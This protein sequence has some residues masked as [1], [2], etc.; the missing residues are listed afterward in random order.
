MNTAPV[1]RLVRRLP[2]TPWFLGP[3]HYYQV[4]ATKWAGPY[5]TYAAA[6]FGWHLAHPLKITPDKE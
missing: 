3:G 5:P 6:A 1:V 4:R 2:S